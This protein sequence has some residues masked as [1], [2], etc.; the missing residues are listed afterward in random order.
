MSVHRITAAFAVALALCA[1]P[2]RAD[3]NI[4][5][6]EGGSFAPEPGFFLNGATVVATDL[7]NQSVLGLST[8]GGNLANV[9][10]REAGGTLDFLYQ[11]QS[12]TASIALVDLIQVNNY[13]G[14]STSV[15]SLTDVPG[16]LGWLFKTPTVSPAGPTWASR[17]LD[18]DSLIT[19]KDSSGGFGVGMAIS[20][21][22][23]TNIFFV[24]TDATLFD[25][26]GGA[27]IANQTSGGVNIFKD[28]FEPQAATAAVPEPSSPL[29]VG[30]AAL[31]GLGVW[32][33]KRRPASRAV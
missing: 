29:A 28:T 12:N 20:P 14:F 15:G 5:P 18:P 26:L 17:S 2:A 10:V 33:W 23:I 11:F 3:L 31:A 25:Q 9:V 22:Q 21:G 16:L 7:T 1:G 6:G 8:I 19:F 27:T 4:S 32:A 13:S 30:F 24:R